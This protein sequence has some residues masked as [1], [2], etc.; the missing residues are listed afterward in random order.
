MATNPA[1]HPALLILGLRRQNLL[2][3]AFE[4]CHQ[5]AMYPIFCL[6]YLIYVAHGQLEAQL[7]EDHSKDR[8]KPFHSP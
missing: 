5:N 1:S 8:C 3:F 7:K 6:I 4:L 2:L